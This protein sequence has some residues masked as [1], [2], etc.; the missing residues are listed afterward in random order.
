MEKKLRK[1]NQENE[2]MVREFISK[3]CNNS[4]ELIATYNFRNQN[5][6]L[7]IIDGLKGFKEY[8]IG[9]RRGNKFDCDNCDLIMQIWCCL[10]VKI[11]E[12]HNVSYIGRIITYETKDGA[13]YKIETDTMNSLE[14]LFN[15]FVRNVIKRKYG[16]T[17]RE[18]YTK[19]KGIKNSI[20]IDNG[21]ENTKCCEINRDEWLLKY[22]DEVFGGLL[23]DEKECYDEYEKFAN[24]VHSVGNF[25]LGPVGFNCKSA[26]AKAK[27]GDRMDL[28]FRG[29]SNKQQ[30]CE[31]CQEWVQWFRSNKGILVL[32]DY[33]IDSNKDMFIQGNFVDLG[34]IK[35]VNELILQRGKAIAKLLLD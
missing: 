19:G 21:W 11:K 4:E 25:V 22:W 30:Q 31:E 5:N 10:L 20:I 18:L 6:Q 17:W 28:F 27:F 2:K 8:K 15:G 29:I 7:Q 35:M 23:P 3:I 32:D 16:T 13:C 33:C 12:A 14:T 34:N 26:N 9:Y 1:F 24:L